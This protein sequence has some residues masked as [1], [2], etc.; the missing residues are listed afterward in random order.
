MNFIY[1]ILVTKLFFLLVMFQLKHFLADYP[2]QG[3]YMLGKF[4]PGWDFLKPLL[5]HVSIHMAFTFVIL[6]LCCPWLLMYQIIGLTLLDGVIHF[7]MDRI[8]ASPKYLGRYKSLD[9]NC[10]PGVAAFAN[11]NFLPQLQLTP[12]QEIEKMAWGKQRLKENTYFWWSLG[13]DQ[14]VHHCTHY[15]IVFIALMIHLLE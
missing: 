13:L 12:E 14:A 9:A 4:K 15:L 6:L 10:Y 8:K 1:A 3:N 2:L 5:A 11:G 7:I